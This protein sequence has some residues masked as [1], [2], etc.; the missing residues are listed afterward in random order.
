MWVGAALSGLLYSG[1]VV[2]IVHPATGSR[3]VVMLVVFT[4]LFARAFIWLFVEQPDE[5]R[6]KLGESKKEQRMKSR[7]ALR[8]PDWPPGS[9]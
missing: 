7:E 8:G 1:L 3:A 2:M 9:N 6:Q 4:V 5:L